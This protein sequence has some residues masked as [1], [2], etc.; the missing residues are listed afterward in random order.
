MN[1]LD[2]LL[3]T[4]LKASAKAG[5]S[6]HLRDKAKSLAEKAKAAV[7]DETTRAAV[8]RV[9]DY[10]LHRDRKAEIGQPA[11]AP[12]QEFAVLTRAG[13]V[14]S[15]EFAW[16]QSGDAL[17]EVEL[18]F[19]LSNLP[20]IRLLER[21]GRQ[22]RDIKARTIALVKQQREVVQNSAALDWLVSKAKS[23]ELVVLAPVLL[24]DIERKSH[25]PPLSQ[26]LNRAL[27]RDKTGIL[28]RAFLERTAVHPLDGSRVSGVVT[29]DPKLAAQF[30]RLLPKLLTANCAG[31]AVKTFQQWIPSYPTTPEAQREQLSG[32]LALLVGHLLKRRK[33]TGP[34]GQVLSALNQHAVS[35]LLTMHEKDAR[36]F[37][38]SAPATELLSLLKPA[39][40][41]SPYGAELI[42]HSIEK[43]G[44]GASADALL[45][46]LA[47]NLG[48]EPIGGRDDLINFDPSV[49]EDVEGGLLGGDPA[50]VRQRGWRLGN[51][52][53]RRA[54][55]A[56]IHG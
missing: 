35:W 54:K 46:A 15:T 36:V 5:K 6:P 18:D 32:A 26:V 16:N 27:I 55:V 11:T 53:I 49:H 13:A 51:K 17:Q 20:T 38:I 8:D 39:E 34:E 7:V 22:T 30:L 41:L 44:G 45:E 4:A 9:A 52:V 2:E 29:S 10:L 47:L 40:G 37:W 25:L 12:I 1:D 43:A 14:R 48:M 23:E 3:L 21:S 19:L 50:K 24:S 33:R 42:A 31:V 28:L 56:D